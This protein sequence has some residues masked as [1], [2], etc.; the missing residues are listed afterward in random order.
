MGASIIMGTSDTSVFPRAKSTLPLPLRV[1]RTKVH[2]EQQEGTIERTYQMRI[3]RSSSVY[4]IVTLFV[5]PLQVISNL[6]LG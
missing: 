1:Q 4:R 2:D 6:H 5:C 3:R